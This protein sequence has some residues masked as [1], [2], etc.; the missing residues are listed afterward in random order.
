MAEADDDS[1]HVVHK[2]KCV[3]QRPRQKL[4]SKKRL[5][6]SIKVHKSILIC[7]LLVISCSGCM[8]MV[9]RVQ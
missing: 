7:C 3:I 9:F 5:T 8:K 4:N 2:L 1:G 6:D